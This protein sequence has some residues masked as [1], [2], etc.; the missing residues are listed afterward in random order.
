MRT[1]VLSL[2]LLLV[3]GRAHAIGIAGTVTRST[4]GGVFPCDIDVFHRSTNALV[5]TG[6]TTATG[7]YSVTLPNG[8]Y[9]V[10]FRPPTTA[11][12]FQWNE[13]DITVNNNT[14]TINPVLD[15]CRFV[16]GRVVGPDAAGVAGTNLRFRDAAGD[17]PDLVQD[18]VTLANGDFF[19]AVNPGVWNV[20]FV[21]PT[22]SHRA[23][24]LIEA[25]NLTADQPLGNVTVPVGFIVTATVT[26]QGFFPVLDARLQAR[27]APGGAKAF[28]PLN[29]T[30]ATGTARIVLPAGTYDFAALPGTLQAF[31]TVTARAI[32]LN[33]DLTLPNFALP[34]G[35]LLSART[36]TPS[37]VSV[38]GV[39]MDV[40]SL[41]PGGARR[42]E[43]P[44]DAT[45]AA[46][47]VSPRVPAWKYRVTF[48][49]P[50]ASRLLSVRVDSV[51]VNANTNMGNVVLPQGHWVDA[52]VVVQGAGTPVAG[53]N[54]DFIRVSTGNIQ[55]T[56]NDVTNGA[57]QTR[58]VVD[59]DLYRLRVIPPSADFDTLIVEGFRSLADT[60]VTLQ[61]HPRVSGVDPS[62]AP[63]GLLLAAP[64]PNPAR[65]AMSVTFAA[66]RGRV[67]LSA[68]D[69]SGRRVATLY[70]G[71]A[72]GPHTVRWSGAADDGAP[73]PTG[74]YWLRLAGESG[75]PLIRR[76]A[77]VR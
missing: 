37:L 47:N 63:A 21:P 59:G 64:W 40:D 8:R 19:T 32:V 17:A 44:D 16:S 4:G 76:V 25:L 66:E 75:S 36:V 53:A 77:F 73:V 39:D 22:A 67:E 46:G 23:P 57:G 74:V 30:D 2:A 52:N 14:V 29:N 61:L 26:D 33:A 18:G 54:L 15:P 34:P 60:V 5:T 28:T 9:I 70:R 10:K 45:D 24:I 13:P 71:E 20:E 7:A 49:P 55:I 58:V 31:G 11:H 41:V 43:T 65:G 69:V 1:A 50:I 68:W 27:V 3:A 72:T 48:N 38:A 42:L 6:A 51:Q 35:F 62:G 12:L 56:T